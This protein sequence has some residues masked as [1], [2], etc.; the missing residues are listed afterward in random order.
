MSGP[1]GKPTAGGPATQLTET[2]GPTT[3]TVGVVADG[4]YL[5]R[6]GTTFVGGTPASTELK[7]LTATTQTVNTATY[8]DIVG[9][10]GFSVTSGVRYRYAASIL[11]ESAATTGATLGVAIAGSVGT[12]YGEA[13]FRRDSGTLLYA[14]I[15][16]V[17]TGLTGGSMDAINTVYESK[18]EGVF[19][20]TATGTMDFRVN[21]SGSG[22]KTLH[23]GSWA[24]ITPLT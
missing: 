3:L 16:A 18:I 22:L 17:D 10:T 21:E 23:N 12:I 2:G 4:E 11:F 20:A 1:W 14:R 8:A 5:V 7:A 24:E 19:T 9:L 13:T 6:S 15:T